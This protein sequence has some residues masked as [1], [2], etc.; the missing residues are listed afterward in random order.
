MIG[1]YVNHIHLDDNSG[2]RSEHLE[3][4][5]GN[6]DFQAIAGYLRKFEGSLNIEL[7]RTHSDNT[8]EQD[9]APVL[10]SREYLLRLLNGT[11]TGD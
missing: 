11:P 2:Q 9:G 4:G 5:R 1:A 6:I 10:R 8:I 3:L 7:K